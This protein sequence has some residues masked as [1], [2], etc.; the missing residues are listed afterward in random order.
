MRNCFTYHSWKFYLYH[1]QEIFRH[2]Y[3]NIKAAWQRITRG[4]ADADTWDLDH[5][6]LEI[7]PEMLEYLRL[8]SHGFPG[9]ERGFPTFEDWSVFL[10]D[11]IIEHMKNARE[12]QTVQINEFQAEMDKYPITIEKDEQGNSVVKINEPDELRK[13]W[14]AREVEISKWRQEEI[15]KALTSLAKVWFECWD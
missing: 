15:E 5:Y 6:L 2:T 10:R 14:F 3:L 11:E 12:D 8:N 7:L 1:P 13:K 4:W 9:P